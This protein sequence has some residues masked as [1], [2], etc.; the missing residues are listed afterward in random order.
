M[1]ISSFSSRF[2]QQRLEW[3]SRDI[4]RFFGLR[5]NLQV[6]A[7]QRLGDETAKRQQM[8]RLMLGNLQRVRYAVS[9]EELA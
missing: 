1:Q 5:E 7:E 4:S 2:S 9:D 6:V 8:E 3:W